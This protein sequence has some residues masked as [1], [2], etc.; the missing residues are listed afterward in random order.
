VIDIFSTETLTGPHKYLFLSMFDFYHYGACCSD[1]K[2]VGVDTLVSPPPLLW[3]LW[4][5]FGVVPFFFFLFFCGVVC[6]FFLFLFVFGVGCGWVVF[7]VFFFFL[8]CVLFFVL[9]IG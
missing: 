8:V 3:F 1:F 7:F 9:F 6:V 4:G 2:F 5:F